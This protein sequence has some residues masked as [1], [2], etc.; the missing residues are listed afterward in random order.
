MRGFEGGGYCLG[1]LRGAGSGRGGGGREVL[2]E[3]AGLGED[4]CSAW[5]GELVSEEMFGGGEL[6]GQL[7]D[8]VVVVFKILDGVIESLFGFLVRV[9]G[10]EAII[11]VSRRPSEKD[12]SC[13]D[14]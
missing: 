6:W 3:G 2:L 12:M 11:G 13:E 10:P 4:V 9:V 14:G 1:F 7:P 8:F 5:G